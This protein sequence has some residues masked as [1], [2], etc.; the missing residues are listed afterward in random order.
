MSV[1]QNGNGLTSN[2]A[3]LPN[4]TSRHDETD[5]LISAKPNY[6]GSAAIRVEG[7]SLITGPA[8]HSRRNLIIK[9][10]VAMATGAVTGVLFYEEVMA[11]NLDNVTNTT[12]TEFAH[13]DLYPD[14]LT[15]NAVTSTLLGIAATAVT[16]GA[17]KLGG[18]II[19]RCR[20]TSR[21]SLL[22]SGVL[23]GREYQH[24]LNHSEGGV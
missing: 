5:A 20:S 22:T 15:T 18:Y 3:G 16:A 19:D 6:F 10:L 24:S 2:G 4:E 9:G 7:E 21:N 1:T 13:L 23:D 8:D 14:R 17:M 12:Q 11:P